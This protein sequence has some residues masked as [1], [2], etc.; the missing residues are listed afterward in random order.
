MDEASP[1]N[2]ASDSKA[3]AGA[4]QTGPA[5]LS[6]KI[7]QKAGRLIFCYTAENYT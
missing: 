1:T 6:L 4:Y 5:C 7:V 3:I 2:Q